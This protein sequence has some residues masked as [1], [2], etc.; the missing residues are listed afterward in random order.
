MQRENKIMGT[1]KITIC[2]CHIEGTSVG[3][4]NVL[5]FLDNL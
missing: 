5:P 2:V 4:N 3:E 1:L